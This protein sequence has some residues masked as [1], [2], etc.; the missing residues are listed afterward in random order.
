[1]CVCVYVCVCEEV[2]SHMTPHA[3]E[4]AARPKLQLKPRSVSGGGS[5]SV[6]VS[7][8]AGGKSDPFGGARP[9]DEGEYERKRAQRKAQDDAAAALAQASLDDK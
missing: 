3:E 1:V 5:G 2:S 9:R 6:G 7:G 8:G 4:R